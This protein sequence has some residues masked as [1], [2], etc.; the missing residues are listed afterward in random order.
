MYRKPTE[1]GNWV[2]NFWFHGP[3]AKKYEESSDWNDGDG[4]GMKNGVCV[5]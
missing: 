3:D 1:K 5:F 2:N 4:G